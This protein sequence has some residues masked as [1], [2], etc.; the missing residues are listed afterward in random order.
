MNKNRFSFAALFRQVDR[1]WIASNA[2]R[3]HFIDAIT[4]LLQ[5]RVRS[6]TSWTS[7]HLNQLDRFRE[8]L[9]HAYNPEPEG[10]DK[11]SLDGDRHAVWRLRIEKN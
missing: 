9:A 3:Q 7:L 6:R 11:D 1:N 5:E 10:I 2:R 4:R 8:S